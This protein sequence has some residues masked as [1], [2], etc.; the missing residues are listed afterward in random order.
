M[1]CC[2]VIISPLLLLSSLRGLQL[3]A[4]NSDV[5][6]LSTASQCWSVAAVNP[7]DVAK[8]TLQVAL[9]LKTLGVTVNSHL[10]FDIHARNVA[11]ACNYHIRAL[12]HVHSQHCSDNRM[13][14]SHHQIRLLQCPSAWRTWVTFSVFK[15]MWRESSG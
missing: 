10:H 11:W 14:L 1:Q 8:S 9:Q 3:S 2:F 7:V 4:D 6:F 13:L 12:H 15:I 5:V